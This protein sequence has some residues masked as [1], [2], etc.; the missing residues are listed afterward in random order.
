[1]KNYGNKA[2]KQKKIAIEWNISKKKLENW[3][4]SWELSGIGG[5]EVENGRMEWKLMKAK[6]KKQKN[7]FERN[8]PNKKQDKTENERKIVELK[9]LIVI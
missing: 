4:G 5:F 9:L 8:Y 3:F 6:Q 1:M 2:D 7:V